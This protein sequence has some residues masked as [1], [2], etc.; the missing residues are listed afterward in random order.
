MKSYHTNPT[1]RPA[2]PW[3]PDLRRFVSWLNGLRCLIEAL[4]R[5]LLPLRRS[6]TMRRD[7][8][9]GYESGADS[10]ASTG[11]RDHKRSH[12][13]T[14]LNH[15][16]ES[17]TEELGGQGPSDGGAGEP[18]RTSDGETE[19]A[20]ESD[21]NSHGKTKSKNPEKPTANSRGKT[22]SKN[23]DKPTV[24]QILDKIA[25]RADLFYTADKKCY[26]TVRIVQH[27][28]N[29]AIQ[30]EDFKRWLNSEF[31]QNVNRVFLPPA[32]A[33][34]GMLRL[35][36]ARAMDGG[37]QRPVF[38]RVAKVD[39]EL[40]VDLGNEKW[41]FVHVRA[42]GW[43]IV[44]PP[45]P[46]PA[47]RH[48]E[49]QAQRSLRSSVRFVRSQGMLPL[50]TPQGGAS[51]E[52]LRKFLPP[53]SADDFRLVVGFLLASLEQSGPKLGLILT[54]P[55]GAGKSFMTRI[56]V[57]LVDP[58]VSP[59]LTIPETERDLI[60]TASHRWLLALDNIS[61]LPPRLSDAFC[62]LATGGGFTHRKLHS[63]GDEFM[64]EVQRPY[65]LNSI[66]D[67]I[68]R[69]DLHD[70][71][72]VLH[73]APMVDRRS[74][75]SLWE[76]FKQDRPRILGAL[77][78][79]ASAALKN[80]PS[81]SPPSRLPR[82][83]D[84]VLFV[85]A[86]EPAFG[87]EAGSFLRACEENRRRVSEASLE[88]SVAQTII[89]LVKHVKKWEGSPTELF[90]AI[91]GRAP[92]W[93][94]KDPTWPRSPEALGKR[95]SRIELELLSA[96]IRTDRGHQG[97][98]RNRRRKICFTLTEEGSAGNKSVGPRAQ[99]R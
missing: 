2:L 67:Q 35:L 79:A 47:S 22:K 69:A 10:E 6:T 99:Q 45:G 96:G 55:H 46:V 49:A 26:A 56:L 19:S 62:R 70:R 5:R 48:A 53:L 3:L 30:S 18:P 40:F 87:W 68:G 25:S 36:E 16:D 61:S 94:E 52:L 90:E 15:D 59:I 92:D 32:E 57:S 63:D 38:R 17:R 82:M 43:G 76:E 64:L 14:P 91:I 58:N 13:E 1:M 27:E 85:S 97:T 23:S 28:E 93:A 75:K 7:G 77:L 50:P 71:S 33:V 24:F 72:I 86:A 12:V 21:S 11:Q 37:Q 81:L 34:G 95:L 51:I 42:D 83:A 8:S 54:G 44:G 66:E 88:D 89:G 4:A 31:F 29:L 73:L 74:E 41:D 80:A 65:I 98:G 78:D 20:G 60:I 84:P 39:G 9:A